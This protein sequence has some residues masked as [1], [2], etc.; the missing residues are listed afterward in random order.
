MD[1][2]KGRAAVHRIAKDGMTVAIAL[3]FAVL[4]M[5]GVLIATERQLER[6][7]LVDQERVQW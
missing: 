7:A 5:G 6:Q 4:A 1:K 2:Q 3:M